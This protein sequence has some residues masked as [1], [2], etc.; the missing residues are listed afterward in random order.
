MKKINNLV[1]LLRDTSQGIY[2][3]LDLD[4]AKKPGFRLHGLTWKNFKKYLKF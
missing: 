1:I 3:F 4:P 2:F